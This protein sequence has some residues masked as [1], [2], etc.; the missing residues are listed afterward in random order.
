MKAISLWQP[1]ATFMHH[2][3][4][5]VETRGW[6]T[7]FRGDLAICSAKRNW[8]PGE[9]GE[10]VE[11]VAQL[12]TRAWYQSN[13]FKHPSRRPLLFP[14][15]YVLCLVE[16]VDCVPVEKFKPS[17][18]EGL[19]GDYTP[20]RFAWVTRNLRTLKQP[21]PVCGRQGF[22]NLP[23]HIEKKVRAQL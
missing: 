17:P 15:G 9:F 23:T 21:V 4:K 7:R 18:L 22:F 20:G 19:L 8:M 5:W 12:I 13:K 16:V 3:L 1:Y 2:S 11:Q 6:P 14:M 10:G